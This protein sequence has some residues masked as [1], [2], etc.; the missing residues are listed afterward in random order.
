MLSKILML[1]FF[2]ALAGLAV[3]FAKLFARSG[4]LFAARKMGETDFLA[5]GRGKLL[6]WWFMLFFV[7]VVSVIVAQVLLKAGY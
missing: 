1:V 7:A 5:R 3:V 2:I 4:D 6:V